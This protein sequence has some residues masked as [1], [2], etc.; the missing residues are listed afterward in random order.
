[1]FLKKT[2]ISFRANRSSKRTSQTTSESDSIA[3]ATSVAVTPGAVMGGGSG[4]IPE[5][6]LE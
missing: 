4:M 3:E 2:N 6:L 5:S 1:M